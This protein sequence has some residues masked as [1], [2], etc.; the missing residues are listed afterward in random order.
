MY[1]KAKLRMQD[2]IKINVHNSEKIININIVFEKKGKKIIG[3]IITFDDITDLIF[4]Q[5][6]AAWSNVAR[7]LA[8]EI[9]NPLTPIN[10][11]AQRI[12]SNYKNNKLN[13]N[14]IENCTSTILRQVNDIKKL[15]TEFSE[16]ARMPNSIFAKADILALINE[17]VRNLKI[18]N[19]KIRFNI[20][21]PKKKILIFCD[22]SKI[23]RLFNNLFKNSIESINEQKNK[24]INIDIKFHQNLIYIY[25]EDN[26]KGFPDNKDILFEPYITKKKGGTGLG[27][28]ICK[29]IVEEHNGEITLYSSK[30]LGGAGVKIILPYGDS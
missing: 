30:I 10:L 12:Q 7:Y 20:N 5:K 16:F 8:H 9:K 17:H 15:V 21:T 27:L 22:S 18:I 2:Q 25:F 28:A 6:Q 11:S 14:I 23:N 3:Y 4:A 29:K 26:G 1:T 19:K 24:T 13:L